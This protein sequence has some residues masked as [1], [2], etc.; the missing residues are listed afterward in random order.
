M[1]QIYKKDEYIIIQVF[2][3]KQR[4]FIVINQNKKD[5][6]GFEKAHTHIKSYK[7]CKY[8]INL[9]RKGKI[10]QGLSVYLLGSLVRLSEDTVYQ[11]KVNKLIK[12]K[13]DKRKKNV[14]YRN[15]PANLM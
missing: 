9:V 2:K 11:D 14:G 15:Q 3:G 8:L 6:L 7:M 4:E 5:R 1:N 12:T 13:K 10:N